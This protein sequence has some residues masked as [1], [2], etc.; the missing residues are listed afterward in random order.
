MG[1]LSTESYVFTLNAGT[2]QYELAQTIFHQIDSNWF[3]DLTED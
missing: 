1:T 2:N 3:V